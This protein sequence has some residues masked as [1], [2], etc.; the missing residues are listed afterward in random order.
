MSVTGAVPPIDWAAQT[1]R[2]WFADHGENDWFGGG[3]AFDDEVRRTLAPWRQALRY[4]QPGDFLRDADTALAAIILFDQVP[5]NSFRDTAEA[6]ATDAL[7]LSI[8]RGVVA[9]RLDRGMRDAERLFAYL[10]FEHSESPCDQDQAV[11]LVSAIGNDAWTQ[12]A[13]DHRKVIARFGRFPHRNA[14]LGRVDRPGEAEAVAG[15]AAW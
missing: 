12:F 10:P 14:A 4:Y 6:F 9:R 7:A 1:L 3:A 11:R 15:G 8:A 5:R 13:I 2:F